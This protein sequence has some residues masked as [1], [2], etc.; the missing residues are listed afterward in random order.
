MAIQRAR[1][2]YLCGE[3]PAR[4]PGRWP[5]LA[6]IVAVG[7]T[8]HGRHVRRTHREP[9][10]SWAK[11]EDRWGLCGV[12]GEGGA[13]PPGLPGEVGR[14]GQDEGSPAVADRPSDA[15]AAG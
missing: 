6:P 11:R 5:P 13:D 14:R 10:A 2:D 7:C 12:C 1:D 4:A 15:S 9:R 8:E 3:G